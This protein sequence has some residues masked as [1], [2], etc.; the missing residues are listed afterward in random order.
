MNWYLEVIKNNYANFEG[1]ARRQEYWMFTLINT[2][3]IMVLYS[4]MFS[5]IDYTTGEV[6]GLGII[7]GVLLGIYALATIVPSIAVSVRRLHD[8]EK[9]G[10]WYLIAFIPFGGIVL[11]VFMCLDGTKG[12]NRFGPDPKA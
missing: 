11:L 2:I 5:S 9:S 8:T 12:D 3:I 6:G 1:R 7:V 4:L 10:W